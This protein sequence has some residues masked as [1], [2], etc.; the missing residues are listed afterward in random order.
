VAVRYYTRS[1]NTEKLARAAAEAVGV[2]ARTI[3][4]PLEERTE[5]LILGASYYAF[6]LDPAVKTFLKENAPKIGT[7]VCV[8]T[9][10]MMKSMYKP[11]KRV[12]DKL[13]ICVSREEYHCPGSFFKVHPGK[14]DAQDLEN[15]AQLACS[16]VAK[17]EQEK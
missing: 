16:V 12:A 10:A 1:G 17:L 9:S 15:V 4:E 14:P 13:G 3:E 11:L 6:D 5:L 8:G 2:Q 7:I